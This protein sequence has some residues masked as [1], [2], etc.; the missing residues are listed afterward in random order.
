MK[1]KNFTRGFVKSCQVCGSS[2]LVEFLNLG[3]HPAVNNFFPSDEKVETI[4]I[5]PMPILSCNDCD[6]VQLGIHV[7]PTKV[8]PMNYAYRSGTTRILIDNFKDLFKKINNLKKLSKEHFIIDIGSNDGTLLSNFHLNGYKVLGVEPTS[9]ANIAVKNGIN[10]L[11]KPFSFDIAN[12]IKSTYSLANV[13]TAANVFAHIE[14]PNNIVKG[15]SLLLE[16][17]GIFVSENHYLI[18]LIETLQYDTFYHEHLRYYSLTSLSSLFK[19]HGMRIFHAEKIPTHGGSIRVFAC[20]DEA[21]FNQTQDFQKLL[22]REPKGKDLTKNLIEFATKT[23]YSK[24]EILQTLTSLKLSMNKIVGISAPSRASTLINY[25]GLDTSIIDYICEV[26]GSLKLG[27]NI[28]GCDI[29]V[30][31]ES[32]LYEDQPPYAI[33]FSWHIADE[34]IKIIKN[35]GFKGKFIIPLPKVKIVD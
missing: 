20:K 10:T 31:E 25:L 22:S 12:E 26:P 35:K 23:L 27:K 5:Y 4:E 9:V 18:D 15:I 19:L 3:Y 17:E 13:I 16:D 1:I 24:S 29:P 11:N 14:D 8:F 33:I 6:L 7:E 34:L 28:P 2:N 32:I 30:I 21:S